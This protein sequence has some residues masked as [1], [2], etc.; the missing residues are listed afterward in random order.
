MA[1]SDHFGLELQI[2]CHVGRREEGRRGGQK[3]KKGKKRK[4]SDG[5]EPDNMP[6]LATKR[7]REK[8]ER[9]KTGVNKRDEKAGQGERVFF[10][11]M[12]AW[13][14]VSIVRAVALLSALT[15]QHEM[16]RILHR[17]QLYRPIR[18]KNES[19]IF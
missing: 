14:Y 16:Q 12:A 17:W 13:L 19:Q 11:L 5:S 2:C 15:K 4:K 6:R 9:E 10:C 7:G 8:I 1:T 3:K 18:Y